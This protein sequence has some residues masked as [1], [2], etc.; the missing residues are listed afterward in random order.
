MLLILRERMISH[1]C[2]R[3]QLARPQFVHPCIKEADKMGL[4]RLALY[5]YTAGHS[6]LLY[7]L[8]TMGNAVYIQPKSPFVLLKRCSQISRIRGRRA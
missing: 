2:R 4:L 7:Q 3:G 5:Q 1:A 6:A 8:T